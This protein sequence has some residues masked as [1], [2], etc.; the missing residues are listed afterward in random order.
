[1]IRANNTVVPLDDASVVVAYAYSIIRCDA[2][3]G[4][5]GALDSLAPLNG[6]KTACRYSSRMQ[7]CHDAG[8]YKLFV[9][10]PVVVKRVALLCAT[11]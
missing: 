1:M 5:P 8:I 2:S 10:S 6:V 7:T 4:G 3:R 11:S 9:F